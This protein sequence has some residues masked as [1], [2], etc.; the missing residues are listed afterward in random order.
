MGY[1][2]S[3]A[4]WLLEEDLLE[5]LAGFDIVQ[6]GTSP[7]LTS[8]LVSVMLWS[9]VAVTAAATLSCCR[10]LGI[11][12]LGISHGQVMLWRYENPIVGPLVWF[13]HGEVVRCAL[14]HSLTTAH[15]T[16]PCSTAQH[17]TTGNRTTHTKYGPNWWLILGKP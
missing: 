11:A 9:G 6:T 15:G 5:C 12:I 17:R 16:I 4:F 10:Y 7:Y 2:Q 14:W 3:K 8:T 13:W 1:D